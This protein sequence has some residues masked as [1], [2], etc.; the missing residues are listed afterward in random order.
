MAIPLP[1]LSRKTPL[2]TKLRQDCRV[3]LGVQLLLLRCDV[4]EI[5]SAARVCFYCKAELKT[6]QAFVAYTAMQSGRLVKWV[7]GCNVSVTSAVHERG[8]VVYVE[9]A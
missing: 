1:S 3:Y 6:E 9:V 5:A 7:E 4:R 8:E 2:S